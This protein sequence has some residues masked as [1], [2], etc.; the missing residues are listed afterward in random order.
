VR[1]KFRVGRHRRGAPAYE[2]HTLRIELFGDEVERMT[3]ID[4]VT[5]EVLET[6][7]RS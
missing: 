7:M 2:E 1:G 4:P 5:G 3:Q 6:L